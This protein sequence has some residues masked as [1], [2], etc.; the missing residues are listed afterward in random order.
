MNRKFKD[1]VLGTHWLTKQER[2]VFCFAIAL[3]LTGWAVKSYRLSHPPS[4]TTENA[5][6]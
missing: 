6:P 2:L 3:L 4:V 1:Y 5:A